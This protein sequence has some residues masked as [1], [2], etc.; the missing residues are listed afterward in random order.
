MSAMEDLSLRVFQT[1]QIVRR[2]TDGMQAAPG[3]VRQLATNLGKSNMTV[4]VWRQGATDAVCLVST[5]GGGGCLDVFRRPFDIS[6][7][8]HDTLGSGDPVAVWGPVTDDV[9]GVDVTANGQTGQAVVENNI[10]F[11]ELPD[12]SL[13]PSAV[14]K[15]VAHLRDGTSVD[16]RV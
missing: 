7:T 3:T 12:A 16:I 13:F 11:Y 1:P 10:A 14:E 4:W 6:I 5:T 8:D 9:V 2:L 15:V